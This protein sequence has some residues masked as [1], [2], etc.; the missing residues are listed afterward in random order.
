[1]LHLRQI[2]LCLRQALAILVASRAGAIEI[3]RCRRAALEKLF[4]PFEVGFGKNQRRLRLIP[5]RALHRLVEG[6]ERLSGSHLLASPNEKLLQR[7]AEGGA[8][9]NE[10]AF[11]VTLHA[12]VRRFLAG[13]ERQTNEKRDG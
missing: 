5:R 11:G 2:P 4:L 10:F 13:R 8:D 3:L 9:V 12:I 1:L 7:S 6:K